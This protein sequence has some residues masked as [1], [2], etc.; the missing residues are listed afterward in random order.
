MRSFEPGGSAIVVG[1]GGGIGAALVSALLEMPALSS[2]WAL[3]RA[4]TAERLGRLRRG[5]ID[6]GDEPSIAAM[7]DCLSN[8]TP[9]GAGPIRL[10]I[11]ATGMLHGQG[12]QPEK[13]YR[14]LDADALMHSYRINAIGPALVAKHMLP[15]LGRRGRSVFAVLSARVGSIGDNRSGG[16][17]SY[18]ASKAALNM[19]LLNLAIE[20]QRRAPETLV[21]GLHPGT[22]DSGLSRPFQR[23]VAE[24]RLFTPAFSAERLLAV[25]DG[26]GTQDN[27]RVLD[28][29]GQVVP[30]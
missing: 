19:I 11:V 10:V 9:D 8:Q 13:S 18:R 29:S 15:L 22:V 23:G 28:W 6:V 21:I 14:A 26:L 17:H 25:I 16:W 5:R 2:V 27:G 1:A 30:P 12:L 7:A 20:T 24:G 4:G 3:S